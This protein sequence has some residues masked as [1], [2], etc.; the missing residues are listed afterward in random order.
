MGARV[1]RNQKAG[2]ARKEVVDMSRFT[3]FKMA[4]VSFVFAFCF[5]FTGI[6]KADTF[7]VLNLNDSGEGSLRQAIIDANDNE[8]GPEVVDEIVFGD[9]LTGTI[10]YESETEVEAEKIDPNPEKEMRITDDVDIIGPGKDVIT[11]DAKNQDRIFSIIK[12][13][14]EAEVAAAAPAEKIKVSISG[15]KFTNGK[16]SG[17]SSGGAIFN[18]QELS[19]DSCEFANNSTA[20]FGGAILN[21]L[22]GVIKEIKDSEFI[23]NSANSGGAI[24][25]LGEAEINDKFIAEEPVEEH[26]LSM[27]SGS[28]FDQ[29]SAESKGGAIIALRKAT[30]GY[31]TDTSFTNNSAVEEGGGA[32]YLDNFDNNDEGNEEKT[33]VESNF[34]DAQY[35]L[36]SLT[37]CEFSNNTS[38]LGGAIFNNLGKIET[39]ADCRF[40]E[41]KAKVIAVTVPPK[42]ETS[43][44]EPGEMESNP[45]TAG[46]AI[47]NAGGLIVNILRTTFSANE[48]AGF[49]GA[50]T[51]VAFIF[52]GIISESGGTESKLAPGAPEFQRALIMKIQDSTFD[53]NKARISGGAIG[54]G[55]SSLEVL[56]TTFDSNSADE[57]GGAIYNID[58]VSNFGAGGGEEPTDKKTALADPEE[59]SFTAPV[60]FASFTTFARNVA[61]IEG[62]A[63]Y[64]EIIETGP[65]PESIHLRHSILALNLGGN[66]GGLMAEDEGGNHSDDDTC[67]LLAGNMA[68]IV[69]DSLADN[70]GPTK[71]VALLEGD[72][73]DSAVECTAITMFGEAVEVESQAIDP[74][75]LVEFDQRGAPRAFGDNCDAGAFE[76]GAVVPGAFFHNPITPA[77]AG[78]QNI[79][80]AEEATPEGPVAFVWGFMTGSTIVGGSTCN[81]TEIGIKNPRILGIPSSS[82][83]GNAELVFFI[84]QIGDS[85]I[86]IKTQAVDL[87]TCETS[88]VIEDLITSTDS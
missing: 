73:V 57:T 22:G 1:E 33:S 6:S 36:K 65:E 51:N 19:I 77:Q 35:Q 74:I 72:P 39:I 16:S 37:D 15:L 13:V 82:T 79:L 43:L 78:S 55:S 63:I 47:L 9:G 3:G 27:L 62:G 41:N 28:S 67:P 69:L 87:N 70:G 4:A 18:T 38:F 61:G 81:G 29:N 10:E 20:G 26:T 71:T 52:G 48:T 75:V 21:D 86:S 88:P 50:I 8:N 64:E 84:P 14:F 31:I 68:N 58:N 5:V 85:G 59:E 76:L 25:V 2:I 53:E 80:S 12:K 49:G 30:I 34:V 83:E 44:E 42:L 66:C 46:G 60:V 32:I 7:T 40:S 11:I 45:N 23:M 24:A 17:M 56:N 54:N